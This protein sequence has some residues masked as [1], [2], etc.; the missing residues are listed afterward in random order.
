MSR[1]KVP[2]KGLINWTMN[3][4]LAL[5]RRLIVPH[6]RRMWVENKKGVDSTFF[7]SIPLTIGTGDK[8]GEGEAR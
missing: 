3:L 6:R 8:T 1:A 4:G 5:S 2:G 7:F